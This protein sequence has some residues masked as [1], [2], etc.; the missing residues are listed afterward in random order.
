MHKTTKIELY[1][2]R[3]KKISCTK[4]KIKRKYHFMKIEVKLIIMCQ[5]K[6][7]KSVCLDFL[8]SSESVS[9]GFLLS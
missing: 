5:D 1:Q 2:R 4:N 8:N 3:Y 7:N 9:Y 6:K